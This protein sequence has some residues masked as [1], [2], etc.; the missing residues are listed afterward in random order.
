MKKPFFGCV[1]LIVSVFLA[2]PSSFSIELNGTPRRPAAA[3]TAS[4]SSWQSGTVSKIDVQGGFLVLDGT[5]RFNFAP[6]TVSVRRQDNRPGSVGLAQVTEGAKVSLT[7]ARNS[8]QASPRV[9]E[10]WIA[11]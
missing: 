9:S 1:G 4:V 10:I 5:R 3:A 2:Q 6:A 11:Q 8:A 7:V